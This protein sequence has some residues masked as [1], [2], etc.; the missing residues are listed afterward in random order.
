MRR[1]SRHG[2]IRSFVGYVS[3][4]HISKF[5]LLAYLP[6]ATQPCAQHLWSL[7]ALSFVDC[8]VKPI[9]SRS[10]LGVQSQLLQLSGQSPQLSS[11][12]AALPL[13]VSDV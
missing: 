6:C 7:L 8:L 4:V 5:L 2:K 9:S 1:K 3:C 13:R 12:L 11:Q 10:I